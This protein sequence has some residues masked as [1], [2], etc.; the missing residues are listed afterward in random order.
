ML[1]RS[2]QDAK[3]SLDT[4]FEKILRQSGEKYHEKMQSSE[5]LL[6][7]DS[8]DRRLSADSFYAIV[9]FGFDQYLFTTKAIRT[10][11]SVVAYM[12]SNPNDEF[13]L[14]GHADEVG[15]IDY[16]TDL[17]KRRVFAVTRYIGSK[18][19][20]TKRLKLSFFGEQRPAQIGRAHV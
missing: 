7:Q 17:S 11:D 8:S 4:N 6:Q 12:K 5:E 13:T 2:Q 20:N 3:L 16:N 19:V 14:L 15:G 1:F 9:Y 10:L 18:G